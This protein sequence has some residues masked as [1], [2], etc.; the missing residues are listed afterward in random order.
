MKAVSQIILSLT[1]LTFILKMAT[2]YMLVSDHLERN[3]KTPKDHL[4]IYIY[5]LLFSDN[6]PVATNE[7][8]LHC[9][10]YI[11]PQLQL[12]AAEDGCVFSS[13]ECLVT[14]LC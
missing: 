7:T 3:K 2:L 4:F 14:P 9:T 13:K 1:T 6:I 10:G 8:N 12:S 5:Q 11:Y